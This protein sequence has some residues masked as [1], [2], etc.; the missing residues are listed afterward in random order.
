MI[1]YEYE[2]EIKIPRVSGSPDLLETVP[3]SHFLTKRAQCLVSGTTLFIQLIFK[4]CL[5]NQDIHIGG[6]RTFINNEPHLLWFEWEMFPHKLDC[7]NN[8]SQLLV[9]QFCK[10]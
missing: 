5:C 3:M 1:N 4:A 9:L 10:V 8:C 2:R 7:L 6:F